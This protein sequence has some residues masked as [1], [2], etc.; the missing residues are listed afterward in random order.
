MGFWALGFQYAGLVIVAQKISIR[1][2]CNWLFIRR[3]VYLLRGS[4]CQGMMSII[5]CYDDLF[6]WAWGLFTVRICRR[7]LLPTNALL[8]SINMNIYTWI[9]C[10]SSHCNNININNIRNSQIFI[11]IINPGLI[12]SVINHLSGFCPWI[13]L[14]MFNVKEEELLFMIV[15][16]DEHGRINWP[17]LGYNWSYKDECAMSLRKFVKKWF[18][19]SDAK[20]T[21]ER[22]TNDTRHEEDL[23]VTSGYILRVLFCVHVYRG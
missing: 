21:F 7:L 10:K 3:N 15:D 22:D 18:G 19:L 2:T 16:C 6:S 1:V 9:Q 14:K 20:C 5:K 23:T 11:K 17:L 12:H 13:W 8:S 4:F